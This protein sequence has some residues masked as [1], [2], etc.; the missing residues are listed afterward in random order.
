MRISLCIHPEGWHAWIDP[1]GVSF[2]S[3]GFIFFLGNTS[4]GG[5]KCAVGLIQ[6][7]LSQDIPVLRIEEKISDACLSILIFSC[8]SA[9]Q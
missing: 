2:I 6:L 4:N 5:M 7:T 1:G 9:V 3:S 8:V